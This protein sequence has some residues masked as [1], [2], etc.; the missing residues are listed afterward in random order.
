MLERDGRGARGRTQ[1]KMNLKSHARRIVLAKPIVFIFTSFN[2]ELFTLRVCSIPEGMILWSPPVE[3]GLKP[4]KHGC[5]NHTAILVTY[6]T[7]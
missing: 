4:A 5:S 1:K 7:S 6:T 3:D 2:K